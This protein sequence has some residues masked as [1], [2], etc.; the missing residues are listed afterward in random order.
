MD[1]RPI[2]ADR[3]AWPYAVIGYHLKDLDAAKEF[4]KALRT[5][6]VVRATGEV[7]TP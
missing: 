3:E 1:Y 2:N 7:I 6:V 5:N 4:A